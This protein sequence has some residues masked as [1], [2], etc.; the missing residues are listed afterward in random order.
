MWLR[1]GE[2][3]LKYYGLSTNLRGF[4]CVCVQDFYYKVR[5]TMTPWNSGD[6]TYAGTEFGSSEQVL[7]YFISLSCTAIDAFTMFEL[8]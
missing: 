5:L 7:R 1:S 4:R 3:A 6:N 2:S 8:N